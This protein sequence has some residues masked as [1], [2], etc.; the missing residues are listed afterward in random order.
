MSKIKFTVEVEIPE[1]LKNEFLN[2]VEERVAKVLD[3]KEEA[4]ITPVEVELLLEEATERVIKETKEYVEAA[5]VQLMAQTLEEKVEVDEV[6][7]NE[8][9]SLESEKDE[10]EDNAFGVYAAEDSYPISETTETT[11]RERLSLKRRI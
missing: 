1:E 9:T 11:V 4:V 5:L 3:K 7:T 6:D 8:D 10:K 2:G